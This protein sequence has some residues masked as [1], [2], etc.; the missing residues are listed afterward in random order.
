M[1]CSN[2]RW[3]SA[4]HAVGL[5]RA[6]ASHALSVRA[7]QGY[8]MLNMFRRGRSMRCPFP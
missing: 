3:A 4:V 7:R 8:K 6:R 2:L 1:S 5:A